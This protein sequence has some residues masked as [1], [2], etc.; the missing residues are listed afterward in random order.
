MKSQCHAF[1]ISTA[2]GLS[3]EGDKTKTKNYVDG[4]ADAAIHQGGREGGSPPGS[5]VE[6]FGKSGTEH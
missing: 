3:F 4:I 2:L 5:L 1:Y 6:I